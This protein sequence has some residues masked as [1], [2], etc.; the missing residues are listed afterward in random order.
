MSTPL[1][2]TFQR[3][4]PIVVGR[5]IVA[6]DPTGYTSFAY[7]KKSAGQ[8]VPRATAPV[9]AEFLVDFEAAASGTPARWVYT[10]PADEA[11]ALAPGFYAVD[12]GFALDSEVVEITEP[13]FVRIV[14]SVSG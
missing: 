14:E 13:A 8:T 9:L 10:I 6:G 5:Q 11:S 4:E 7:L 3:G 2:Y 12:V 1:V